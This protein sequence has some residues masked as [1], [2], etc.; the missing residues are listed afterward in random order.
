MYS[1]TS[2][3]HSVCMLL[4]LLMQSICPDAQAQPPGYTMTQLG[5][6]APSIWPTCAFAINN[7]GQVVGFSQE[8][9]GV[10]LN[11]VYAFR[12]QNGEMISLG[13]LASWTFDGLPEGYSVATAINN[14]GQAVGY[15][16]LPDSSSSQLFELACLWQNGV[17]SSLG[18]LGG[19][20]SWA[21]SINNSGQV[22]GCA[23]LSNGQS[24]AFLWQSGTMTDLGTL[25][26]GNFSWAYG[27]ND[28]EL[29]VGQADSGTTSHAFIWQS[30]V[31]TDL[32][33]LNPTSN[34]SSSC[35][36]AVNNA[37][38]VVGISSVSGGANHAFLWEN[39]VM[40]DLGTLG[41]GS[42]TAYAINN[43][44]QVVGYSSNGYP[45]SVLH[46]FIWQN[47]VMTDLGI[48]A[49]PGTGPFDGSIPPGMGINDYGQIVG[50]TYSG[51]AYLLTP[52]ASSGAPVTLK[53][54]A[55][56]PVISY[57]GASLICTVTL[58]GPASGNMAAIPI[59]SSNTSAVPDFSVNFPAGFTQFSL[60]VKTGAV[61]SSTNVT[62]SAALNGT[63]SAEVITLL[64]IGVSSISLS[65]TTVLGSGGSAATITLQAPS[66]GNAT[67]TLV[68]SNPAVAKPKVA[69]L[70]VPPGAS[71]ALFA[72]STAAVSTTTSVTFTATSNGIS[73]NATLTVTPPTPPNLQSLTLAPSTATSGKPVVG[74]VTLEMPVAAA[75]VVVT[76]SS[77]SPSIAQVPATL[78]FPN[79]AIQASFEITT[80][81]VTAMTMITITA[82]ANGSSQTATLTLTPPPLPPSQFAGNWFGPYQVV[83]GNLTGPGT[84]T[85]AVANNGS[86]SG[87]L[88]NS[89]T[90]VSNI[91]TGT[92]SASGLFTSQNTTVG[93]STTLSG[94]LAI[95]TEKQLVGNI[96]AS[97]VGTVLGVYKVTLVMK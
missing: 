15:S 67:V 20:S 31:M 61:A 72:I 51:A 55:I 65:P 89:T 40:T 69:S 88:Y 73:S 1:A 95:N 11:D 58:S 3:R 68:S 77:S 5:A 57:G 47:G 49:F 74:T 41:P 36:Y 22:V 83:S 37:G 64:P 96:Q 4:I 87:A 26:G 93:L 23:N 81:A 8:D 50:G 53:S 21:N 24:H 34:S 29:V 62:L 84:V 75:N 70:R 14:V 59:F 33:S 94:T 39:G 71:R 97:Q 13:T 90:K 30:G 16:V 78:A 76:L 86:I 10:T 35:A 18:T 6:L 7:L 42:S 45:N 66:T 27:I 32:G 2:C 79:G 25:P 92:I 60:L 48:P 54:L 80:H 19:N 17:I 82:T 9:N 91:F 52:N 46:S 63:Q 28:A 38:Q 44:G 43:A 12:W 85:I 56:N